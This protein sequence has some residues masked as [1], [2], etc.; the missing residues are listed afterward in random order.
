MI[1]QAQNGHEAVKLAGKLRPAVVI[2]DI[3]MP[4]LNGLEATRQIL[5]ALPTTSEIPAT[6]ARRI[7]NVEVTL[8]AVATMSAW[9]KVL[10]SASWGLEI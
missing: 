9:F 4:L 1:G 8:D 3:A 2:M 10:K 5:K 6:A 7:V